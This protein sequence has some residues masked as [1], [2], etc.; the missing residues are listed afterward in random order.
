VSSTPP[1][2][3]DSAVRGEAARD[4]EASSRSTSG[5]EVP[6]RLLAR[7]TLLNLAG[8]G[9]PVLFVLLAAPF[10]IRTL[11]EARCGILSIN[12]VIINF[13]TFFDLG[14]G[15]ALRKRVGEALGRGDRHEVPKITFT[16]LMAQAASGSLGALVL[17]IGSPLLA[18]RFFQIP[19]ELQG[20]A[21]A[22]FYLLALAF[23]L[24]IVTDSLSG[25]L[26]AAQR[27]DLVNALRVPFILSMVLL[28][29]LGV[30]FGFYL[31]GITALQLGSLFVFVLAH[32]AACARVFPELLRMPTFD[33]EEARAL[34]G[35]G[36]W[37]IIS[38]SIGPVLT[39]LDRLAIGM[40]LPIAAVT[41]YTAP[42]ELVTRLSVVPTSLAATLFPA[43]SAL[44]GQGRHLLLRSYAIRSVKYLSYL[45]GPIVLGVMVFSHKILE[46]WLGGDFAA[47]SALALQILAVGV[48]FN[49]LAHVPHA[50]LDAQNRPDLTAK[51]HMIELPIHAVLVWVLV[52]LWGIPG[53][54]LAWTLR[55]VLDA[56]LLAIASQQISN[57]LSRS[58][59]A[60]L[61]ATAVTS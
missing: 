51:F 10:L 52:G 7:N 25:V 50:W 21:S 15:R 6:G 8:Q 16:A 22:T 14:L 27:F 32:F 48:L 35:F 13:S 4:G 18:E 30:Q 42:Y 44:Y 33:R 34:L 29:L 56:A 31:V 38:N 57:E 19:I 54:A 9:V 40:L 53:A 36:G 5:L 47:E 26:E 17:A 23:P 58:E 61:Q 28:P 43:F 3:S 39:Y 60:R 41:A 24:L 49:S 11:G 55:V 59:Q 2:S 20:E 46:V 45:L 1:Q 37:V 12:L